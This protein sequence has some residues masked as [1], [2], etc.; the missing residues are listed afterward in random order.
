MKCKVVEDLIWSVGRES[1]PVV[2]D[3]FAKRQ[4]KERNGDIAG[5]PIIPGQ[6]Y[7]QDGLMCLK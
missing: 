5:D 1:L 7:D 4:E 2:R 3:C 6:R